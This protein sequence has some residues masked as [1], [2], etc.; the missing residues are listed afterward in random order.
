MK[1]C[2]INSPDNVPCFCVKYFLCNKG[3]SL[4]ANKY[5]VVLGGDKIAK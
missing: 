1:D 3:D 5:K 2:K 4:G